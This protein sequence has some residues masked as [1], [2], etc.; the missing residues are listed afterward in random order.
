VA[1]HAIFFPSQELG[2]DDGWKTV[3][4]LKAVN[5]LNFEG[6]KIS[7]STGNGI[8]LADAIN[9][10]PADA[11]RYALMS[12]APETD[13]TDFT[14]R[15]FA[16]IVNKDLNGMLGNFVS[17]V[18]KLAEKNFGPRVPKAQPESFDLD[19]Q[20]NE[21]LAELTDALDACKLRN[22]VAAL[23][24]LWA[25][26]NEFMTAAEPWALIKNGEL[27]RAAAVLNE[28]FQLMDLYARASKPFIPDAADKI[29]NVFANAR[30]FSWPDGF[31]RRIQ[32][33]EEFRVPENL[34][35]RIDDARVAE[36]IEKYS[37]KPANAPKIVAA[38]IL[39]ARPHPTNAKLSVLTVDDGEEEP[40]QIVC[41]APNVR[42]GF[43][44]VLAR[45][46]AVLPGQKKPISKRVVQNVE[47]YGM[48]L[49]A[50]EIGAGN[51]DENI[52]ELAADTAP[53]SEYREN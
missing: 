3:D 4:M 29:A 31:Q 30:D 1:F 2:V 44:G 9:D 14:V 50:A 45:V 49:S 26:G 53:G 43:V 46:G 51:D 33:G 13:D 32:D 39:D 15:R 21:K 38:R 25:I 40:L 23:R 42:A 10:A 11:W 52:L 28:C 35:E 34:F 27:D 48:M 16:E 5:F 47:S 36:M 41:G 20:V 22:A 37:S 12:S 17:R 24:G 6:A 7:K 18:S 8:F 19:A